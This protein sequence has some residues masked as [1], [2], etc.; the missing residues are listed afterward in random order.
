MKNAGQHATL[1][2]HWQHPLHRQRRPAPGVF[3][4]HSSGALSRPST[5]FFFLRAP[6]PPSSLPRV[7][8]PSPVLASRM[9]TAAL[10][11]AAAEQEVFETAG[12][13]V[14]LRIQRD[15][16]TGAPKGFGFCE[17]RDVECA[18]AAIRILN[19]YEMNGRLLSVDHAHGN[20]DKSSAGPSITRLAERGQQVAQ[21]DAGMQAGALGGGGMGEMTDTLN[22]MTARQMYELIG[23]L[24]GHV[25]NAEQ[26]KALMTQNHLLCCEFLRMQ[27]R[28]GMLT[29][30]NL[31]APPARAP[32]KT[33]APSAL[34]PQPSPYAQNAGPAPGTGWNVP[35]VQPPHL[36]QPAPVQDTS[37]EPPPHPQ[38]PAWESRKPGG[39]DFPMGGAPGGHLGS[40]PPPGMMG[41]GGPGGPP[42]QYGMQV[43]VRVCV[44]TRAF[45]FLKFWLAALLSGHVCTH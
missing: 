17:F 29:G 33:P 2:L 40:G 11:L 34:P 37:A 20:L 32:P 16:D 18:E 14:S 26:A 41:G 6:L 31:P 23:Q 4:L 24:K 22:N 43:R 9:R 42:A 5:C 8:R 3:L 35:Q 25:E 27:E 39:G 10:I 38:H 45:V 1:R 36:M 30:I 21:A 12:P 28:L 7:H 19:N 44:R 13:V 15:K